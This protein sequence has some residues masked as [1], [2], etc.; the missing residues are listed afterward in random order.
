VENHTTQ[1]ADLGFAMCGQSKQSFSFNIHNIS[2]S[3]MKS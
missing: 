3:T 2:K 1:F